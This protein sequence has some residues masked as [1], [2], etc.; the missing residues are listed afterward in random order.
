MKGWLDV[1]RWIPRIGIAICAILIP[2]ATISTVV[3]NLFHD[4]SYYHAG[5]VRY[6]VAPVTGYSQDQLDRVDDGIVRFFGGNESLPTAIGAAGGP[7]DIFSERAVLHMNDVRGV[8][9]AFGSMQQVSLLIVGLLALFA[10]I[11]WSKAGRIAIARAL[12]YSSLVTVMLGVIAI[13]LTFVGFDT[14]FI[15][16]HELVFHN[17]YWQL[18]P[19]T[20]HLVQ[21]FPFEFWFDA[22]LALALRI[23]LVTVVLGGLGVALGR[24]GLASWRR[25]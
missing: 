12:V 18:D 3:L 11:Q 20:D 9:Q 23:V 25:A 5:Q 15:T 19:L 17:D 7:A 22:M 13:G 24:G 21:M 4:S 2:L 8:I 1:V 6:Q 14:L 16:F 10:L